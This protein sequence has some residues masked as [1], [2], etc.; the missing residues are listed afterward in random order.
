MPL[1]LIQNM[2]IVA[3]LIALV[4]FTAFGMLLKMDSMTGNLAQYPMPWPGI[5]AL[6]FHGEITDVKGHTIPPGRLIAYTSYG[7]QFG[8]G[9][10]TLIDYTLTL[11]YGWHEQPPNYT[12]T[13]YSYKDLV[14]YYCTTIDLLEILSQPRPYSD[15]TIF[16]PM[17]CE[18]DLRNPQPNWPTIIRPRQYTDN[19]VMI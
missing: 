5:D 12:I 18:F 16:Y 11:T 3:Y 4:A 7:R 6:T 13:Y 10:I 15:S 19:M 8:E 1:Q 14:E 2:R 9:G 17:Q